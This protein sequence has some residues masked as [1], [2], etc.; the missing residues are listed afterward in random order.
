[1]LEKIY[2]K[3]V[4]IACSKLFVIRRSYRF[5]ISIGFWIG[6]LYEPWARN[7]NDKALT[8]FVESYVNV[9]VCTFLYKSLSSFFLR[10]KLLIQAN[11]ILDLAKATNA[12]YYSPSWHGPAA[13]D[14]TL[15]GQHGAIAALAAAIGP[16]SSSSSK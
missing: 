9:Q 10:C 8:T 1:M 5:L 16:S 11:A 12:N 3:K 4:P 2:L 7:L 14:Y 6:N 15:G 13:T